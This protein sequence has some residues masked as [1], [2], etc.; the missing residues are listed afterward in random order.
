MKKA[1]FSKVDL[2]IV[3]PVYN[4]QNI[5]PKLINSIYLVLKKKIMEQTLDQKAKQLLERKSKISNDVWTL[6]YNGLKNKELPLFEDS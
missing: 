5:L 3:I 4:S 2:S 6:P 1:H